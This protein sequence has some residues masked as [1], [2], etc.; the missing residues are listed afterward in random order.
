MKRGFIAVT[1]VAFLVGS[2]AVATSRVYTNKDLERY[3]NR[4]A[5]SNIKFK[6]SKISVNF[7]DADVY[8]VL[9]MIAEEAKKKDGVEI[10]VSPEISGRITIKMLNV[11]WTEILKEIGQKNNLTEIYL[12]KRTMLITKAGPAPPPAET[13]PPP[14]APEK[15]N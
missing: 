14:A 2:S 1:I 12:G 3:G 5:A 6:A 9:L 10:F 15:G 7:L 4:P 11:P 8:Q 13:A